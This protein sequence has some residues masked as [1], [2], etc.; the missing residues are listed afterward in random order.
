MDDSSHYAGMTV[1]ERLNE[2]GLLSEF[3]QAVRLRDRE[4]MLD[5]LK[6]VGMTLEQAEYTAGTIL[7]NSAHYGY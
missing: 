7:D 4:W 2:A 1:N 6:K 5:I 3:D